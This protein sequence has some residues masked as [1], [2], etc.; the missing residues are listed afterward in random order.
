[1][2]K[3]AHGLPQVFGGQALFFAIEASN[4][5]S[6]VRLVVSTMDK[7]DGG[8]V[9]VPWVIQALGTAVEM[10]CWSFGAVA[11]VRSVVN[12]LWTASLSAFVTALV[13]PLGVFV[14]SVTLVSL[15]GNV[16]GLLGEM[17]KVVEFARYSMEGL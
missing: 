6:C 17:V 12:A 8:V 11:E 5:G 10:E 1:M 3:L 15:E 14:L 2:E 16:I 4:F 9:E 13:G 7:L